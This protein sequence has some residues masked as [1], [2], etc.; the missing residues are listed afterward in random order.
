MEL[1]CLNDIIYQGLAIHIDLTDSKSW[2][3]NNEFTSISLNQWKNA[4]SDSIFLYDFGLT[5]FDNGR[6]SK[7]YDTLTLTPNDTKVQL[8]RVG[9]N[10]ETGGT[11]YDGYGITGVTENGYGKRTKIEEFRKT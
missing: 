10:T 8:Y 5:A 3:L 4:K 2:N 7:M 11:F 9:Y 6:V 1:K